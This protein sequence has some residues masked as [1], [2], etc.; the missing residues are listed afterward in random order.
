[1]LETTNNLFFPNALE[2]Y[3]QIMDRPLDENIPKIY[4]LYGV[5]KK[6]KITEDKTIRNNSAMI[7]KTKI[8]EVL[9]MTSLSSLFFDER[10]NFKTASHIAKKSTGRAIEIKVEM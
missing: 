9:R 7:N 3:C 8:V 2:L 6:S 1:M 4:H 10:T 5:S